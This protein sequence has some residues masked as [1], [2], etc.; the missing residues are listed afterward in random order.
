VPEVCGRYTLAYEDFQFMLDYYGITDGGGFSYPPR[1][2]IAPGQNVP[3]VVHDG[4]RRRIGLLRW[5]LVPSWAKDDKIGYKM[6]NARAETLMAKST[7][8]PL[9]ARKRCLIPADGFFEWKKLPDGR[10]QAMRII[11]KS[12]KLF[13]LAGLYDTWRTPSGD[14]LSTCTIITVGANSLMEPIHNRMPAILRR[15]E[16]DMWIDKGVVNPESLMPLLRSFDAA[17]MEAYPVPALVG[18]ANNDSPEC[19]QRQLS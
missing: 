18:S 5:G 15:D 14:R 19:I 13:S 4:Q 1:Y 2:N 10:K 11:L 12:Q 16:E 7:F 6:I 8:K 17:D 9:L 3:A